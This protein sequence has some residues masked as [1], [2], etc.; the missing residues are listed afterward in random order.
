MPS[1][2]LDGSYSQ[3]P[4]GSLRMSDYWTLSLW[5]LGLV[6][7]LLR[8]HLRNTVQRAEHDSYHN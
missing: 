6:E 8:R 4:N 2:R 5:Q 1:V 7:P 3:K